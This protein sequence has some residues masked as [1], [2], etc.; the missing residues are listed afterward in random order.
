MKSGDEV[1]DVASSG[2]L[3]GTILFRINDLQKQTEY[4]F[5]DYMMLNGYGMLLGHLIE[6]PKKRWK[7]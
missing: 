4:E 6:K 3:C 7:K 2:I 5:A 1:S